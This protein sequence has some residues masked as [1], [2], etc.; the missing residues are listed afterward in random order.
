MD[1]HEIRKHLR[2]EPFRPFRVHLSDGSSYDV[3]HPELM[4]VSRTEIAIA[5]RLESDDIP[6]RMVSCD[7]DYV[8]RI[9]TLDEPQ[10]SEAGAAGDGR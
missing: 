7:P 8:T 1:A 10:A 5:L 9:E 4:A 2:R 6:D 3:E